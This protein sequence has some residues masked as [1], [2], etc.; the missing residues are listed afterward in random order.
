MDGDGR[1]HGMM[2]CQESSVIAASSIETSVF[3]LCIL[4]CSTCL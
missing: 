2:D 4:F 1:V 3:M